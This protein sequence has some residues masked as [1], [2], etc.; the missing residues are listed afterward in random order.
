MGADYAY[1]SHAILCRPRND[2]LSLFSL[3]IMR[4]DRYYTPKCFLKIALYRENN[5]IESNA[6]IP[7]SAF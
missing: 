3:P 1:T 4:I 5:A 6:I 2:L 7:D